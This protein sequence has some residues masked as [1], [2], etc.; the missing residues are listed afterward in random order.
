MPCP[1]PRRF[2]LLT[3]LLCACLSACG[4]RTEFQAESIL[5]NNQQEYGV[6]HWNAQE[7]PVDG[8][9][10]ETITITPDIG[11]V[12]FSGSIT[13][14]PTQ[15]T[16]YRMQVETVDN[17]GLVYHYTRSATIHIGPRADFD[18]VQDPA[19]RQCLE[20]NGFTHLEQFNV[21]YC[22][23]RGITQLEGIQQFQL[24]QSVSLDNNQ[25]TDL[26]PLTALPQLTTLS[27]SGNGLTG[28]GSLMASMSVHNIAA[29]NNALTDVTALGMM[30]QL[31]S[32]TLDNNQISDP[33][34]LSSIP[35]LQGLSIRF[36]QITDAAT[37]AGNTELLALDIS[38]NPL[39]SGITAL[40]TLTKASVIR[41]ENNGGILCLDYAKL[42]LAL[43]PV[44][45][46]DRCRLF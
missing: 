19:L 45:L 1:I 5:D 2:A 40:D 16:T 17:N 13:V 7:G 26:T 30:P 21:I 31:L 29:H 43:G 24:T 36:N 28:L 39:T 33:T 46:F 14:Y 15:T 12:G 8:F 9:T 34:P 6:L 4:P 37:L 38:D 44:V 18:L 11:A 23:D 35:T 32:L 27:V 20:E 22:L 3:L 41:S 10:I 25:L 42:V